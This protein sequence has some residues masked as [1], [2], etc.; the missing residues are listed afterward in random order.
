[1][2]MHITI[3]TYSYSYTEMLRYRDTEIRGYRDI[4]QLPDGVR[5]HGVVA[6]VPRFPNKCS[7]QNV[8]ETWQHVSN[9]GNMCALKT[10]N[11]RM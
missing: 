8:G 11:D 6:E 5:T 3:H 9:Y 4:R 7:S 10:N 1:M 2:F